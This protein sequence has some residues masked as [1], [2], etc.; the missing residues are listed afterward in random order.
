MGV[1]IDQAWAKVGGE[2]GRGVT[3]N[4]ILLQLTMNL[5]VSLNIEESLADIEASLDDISPR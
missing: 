1:L 5:C 3:S 2:D 4:E